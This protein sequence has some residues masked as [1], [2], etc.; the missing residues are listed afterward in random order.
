MHKVSPLSLRIGSCALEHGH[1]TYAVHGI[2]AAKH[3]EAQ[4]VHYT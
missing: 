3:I 1:Q 2:Q 4:R